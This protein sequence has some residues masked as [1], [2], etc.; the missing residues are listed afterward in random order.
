MVENSLWLHNHYLENR[1]IPKIFIKIFLSEFFYG[2]QIISSETRLPPKFLWKIFWS[3]IFMLAKSL[4]R[5]LVWIKNFHQNFLVENFL[6]LQNNF[7]G[8]WFAP[9]IFMKNFLVKNFYG[10]KIVT[11][12]PCLNK[13]LSL[14]FLVEIFYGCKIVTSKTGL[15]KKISSTILVEN[16]LWLQNYYLKINFKS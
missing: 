5:N 11:S 1:S 4:P 14:K 9:K 15:N 7:L 13:K 12:K 16:F 6:W 8:I 10:C 3:K 2:C